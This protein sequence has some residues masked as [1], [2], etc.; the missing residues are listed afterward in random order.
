ML[1]K[2]AQL[3]LKNEYRI[4]GLML[5]SLLAA[6]LPGQSAAL[7]QSLLIIHFGF[8]LLWQ[9][10]LKQQQTFNLS[11]LLVLILLVLT[12]ILWF[13]PWFN[14][15]WVLILLS[16]LTGRIFNRGFE[17]IVYGY[18]VFLLLLQLVLIITPQLFGLN[19]LSPAFQTAANNMI[20]FAPLLLI[21]APASQGSS[22]HVDFIRGFLVVL[23]TI[24]LCMSS[25]LVSFTTKQAYI[26]SLISSIGILSIFLII[27]SL[28]WA[29]PGGFAGLAQIWEKYLLN[30]GG[31][32]EQWLNHIATEENKT[33]NRPLE[34]LDA[35]L[36]YLFQQPWVSGVTYII[37]SKHSG[38]SQVLVGQAG[39][40]QIFHHDELIQLTIYTH[41]SVGPALSLH[42]KLILRVLVFYYR[43]KLQEQQIIKQAHLRAIYETGSK[44]T[45][46]VKNILQTT[47]TMT[48]IIN[49]NDA[50]MQAI[51]AVLKKQMPLL[52]QR[53]QT[54]LNKL[55]SPQS[56]TN[57]TEKNL[58]SLLTWWQQLQLRYQDSFV[59][60][61][62][63]VTD[64]FVI[65]F[66]IYNTV[67][68]NLL[69]NARNKKSREPDIQVNACLLKQDD[70]IVFQVCDT[71]S[72]F[73]E[74][75]LGLLFEEALPSE[76]GY[77]IGLYQSGELAKK[78]HYRLWLY[79]NQPQAVCFRLQKDQSGSSS[80]AEITA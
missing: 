14:A 59:N 23:L 38:P 13:N 72:A 78:H 49:D 7:A 53:L 30:I 19:G 6:I 80:N 45:H 66:D 9:P 51:I 24:F 55:K 76:D 70:N 8:F 4:L 77:G 41:T 22:Q 25:V 34:F 17:R 28:L 54:T 71:G 79:T 48:Q 2:P 33:A 61:S 69:E 36:Q 10:L 44:L 20:M 18:A 11:S 40:H 58:I 75:K 50:E 74:D 37:Q 12:F 39:K 43:A 52:N 46:D 5:F 29:P 21:L 15:F 26:P 16:L 56:S 64:D 42:A 68:E 65:P 57:S 67:A 62:S 32:F 3:L 1:A 47:Q 27:T 35:S 73:P 31:P 60:F 63:E